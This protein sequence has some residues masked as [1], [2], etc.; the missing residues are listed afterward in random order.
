MPQELPESV[1]AQESAEAIIS[2]EPSDSPSDGK[3]S[4]NSDQTIT[5]QASQNENYN[6]K[7][8]S[9]GKAGC[10]VVKECRDVIMPRLGTRNICKTYLKCNQKK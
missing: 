1:V 9:K 5:S 2:L 8:I 3:D 7:E 6:I 10:E 4:S